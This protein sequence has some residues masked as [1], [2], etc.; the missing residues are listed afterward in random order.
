MSAPPVLC[1][2][3]ASPRRRELL[4]QI[5]VPHSVVPAAIDETA[6][7]FEPP[8]DYVLR[9]ARAKAEAVAGSAAARGLPVLAADT[10]VVAGGRIFAKPAGP[11]EALAM[12]ESL[13]GATHRVLS[14]VVLAAGGTLRSRTAES[15]VRFRAIGAEE[16]R[17]YCA[18]LEPYDKAGGYA[19]QG[20]GAVFVAEIRG[21][22][23]GVMGLP[24]CETA[25]LLRNAGIPY[26][27][28]IGA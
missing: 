16:R 22:Y 14:A 28:N 3:S 8:H 5:G 21:S 26:W 11:E 18:T 7:P 1:L 10:S 27:N 25:E 6:R 4:T 12:L 23:S 19:I 2:A 15:L 20:L 13:S 24:L 17:A 9:V